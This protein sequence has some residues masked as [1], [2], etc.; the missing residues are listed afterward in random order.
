MR[1]RTRP[2]LPLA[3][4]LAITACVPPP[5]PAPAPAPA[6]TPVAVPSPAPVSAPQPVYS[7]WRDAPQTPGDW[8]YADGLA[9]FGTPGNPLL[10]VRCDRAAG[11]IE[12]A[13]RGRVPE[14][15]RILIKTEAGD[16]SNQT[17]GISTDP[18]ATWVRLPVNDPLL[19]AIAYSSGRFAVQTTWLP[20][21]YVPSW[22]EVMRVIDDCR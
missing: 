12:L 17:Q 21:L 5:K 18:P 14:P 9:T 20:T 1:P 15:A 3:A 13:R 8:S 7:D 2:L 10:T 4:V 11:F 16:G 19:D 6:P 22:P